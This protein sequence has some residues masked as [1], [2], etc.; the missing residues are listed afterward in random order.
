MLIFLSKLETGAREY[1]S[2]T[3]ALQV[4]QTTH[5]QVFLERFEGLNLVAMDGRFKVTAGQ[6]QK[7]RHL[8]HQHLRGKETCLCHRIVISPNQVWTPK[9]LN[10]YHLWQNMKSRIF[11]ILRPEYGKAR[12]PSTLHSL[13]LHYFRQ[14]SWPPLLYTRLNWAPVKGFKHH[15][16]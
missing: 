10:K 2:W 12:A 9:G 4:G 6:K 14:G 16:L 11:W 15:K 13:D 3:C 5:H 8:H 7:V 1:K